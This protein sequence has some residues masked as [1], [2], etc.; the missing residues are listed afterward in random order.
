MECKNTT[1]ARK[2]DNL[3]QELDDLKTDI[4]GVAETRWT[5]EGCIKKENCT[6]IH[7][8]GAESTHGDGFLINNVILKHVKG[9][10]T[11]DVSY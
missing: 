6:F 7:S 2:T 4:I 11:I 5:N 8:G 1:T 9:Y 3:C 10:F